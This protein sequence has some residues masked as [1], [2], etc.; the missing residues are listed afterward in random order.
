MRAVMVTFD[1]SSPTHHPPGSWSSISRAIPA[2]MARSR[3]G[4]AIALN[5]QPAARVARKT[6]SEFCALS[7]QTAHHPRGF[8]DTLIAGGGMG[9]PRC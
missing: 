1:S 5:S 2:S 3:S 7:L 6:P 4:A 8:P 9:W